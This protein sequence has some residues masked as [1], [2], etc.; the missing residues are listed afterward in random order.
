M[1]FGR[2]AGGGFLGRDVNFKWAS[3]LRSKLIGGNGQRRFHQ[4]CGARVLR[5]L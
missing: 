2:Q 5:G 3:L 1:D 4:I